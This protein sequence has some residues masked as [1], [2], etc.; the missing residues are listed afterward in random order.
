[1]LRLSETH[2]YLQA[3]HSEKRGMLWLASYPVRVIGE[4]FKRVTEMLRP[5][6]RIVMPCPGAMTQKQ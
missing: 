5:P 4:Y 1:M 2:R 6:Y 3:H